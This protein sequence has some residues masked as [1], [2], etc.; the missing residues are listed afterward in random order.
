MKWVKLITV[1]AALLA[2]ALSAWAVFLPSSHPILERAGL[3][4]PMRAAGLPIPEDEDG[5]GGGRGGPPFGGGGGA[6]RVVAQEVALADADSRLSA[7]GTAEARRSVLLTSEVAGRLE[8]ITIASGDWVEAGQMIAAIDAEAQELAV[9][10]AGVRL[11]DAEARMDRV[12]RLRESGTATDVQIQDAELE[13]AQ[14]RLDLRDAE[15]EL[16]RRQIIAPVEGWVG[17]VSLEPGN[18]ITNGSELVRIDDRATLLIE[19]NVPE[20]FVGL[21]S[22]DDP[23]EVSPLSRPDES[24]EG[25]IRAIDARVDQ[26]NRTL[27]IQGEIDNDDDRLRPGMAF[28]ITVIL[29]GEQYPSIDPLAIQWDRRGSF[30]WALDGDDRAQRVGIE[31]LRR[32]DDAVLVR[33]DLEEGQRV[34][35]EGVQN[36]R[37]GA[38]VDVA[39]LVDPS[40]PGEGDQTLR[41]TE[42]GAPDDVA[43]DAPEETP[44]F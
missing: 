22:V 43:E 21:V 36:L 24:A 11:Q 20:R 12:T 8:E 44:E 27:R 32:H 14:A 25:R 2:L 42:G 38:G 7:I 26:D 6:V 28:R 29:P 19:F 5:N 9:E 39:E 16:R 1:C 33:A 10:R 40:V 15:F 31:I 35:L 4:E 37:P 18:Q 34:V 41:L 3:L 13:L 23:L 17:L 30:V